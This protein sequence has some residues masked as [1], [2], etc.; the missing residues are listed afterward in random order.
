MAID[1]CRKDVPGLLLGRT[2]LLPERGLLLEQPASPFTYGPSFITAC[3]L[4]ERLNLRWTGA[5]PIES[6]HT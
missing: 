3:S 1:M 4:N 6:I 2:S 5:K